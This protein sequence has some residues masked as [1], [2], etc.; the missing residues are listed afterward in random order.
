[1][2]LI[3]L[4]STHHAL[5]LEHLMKK[6]NIASITIPTPRAISKSCGMSIKH[7]ED[8]EFQRLID[9]ATEHQLLVVGIFV[10]HDDNS[11]ERVYTNMED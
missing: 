4:K 8:V 9:H 7:K 10:V 1:M 11:L 6:N 3:S 2:Y 5:M